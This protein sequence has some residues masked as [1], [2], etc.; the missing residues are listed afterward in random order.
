MMEASGDGVSFEDV[1]TDAFGGRASLAAFEG[2]AGVEPVT[3]CTLSLVVSGVGDPFL[4]VTEGAF[5]AAPSS[6]SLSRPGAPFSRTSAFTPVL[7]FDTDTALEAVAFS[8]RSFASE[9]VAPEAA[10]PP[11]LAASVGPVLIGLTVGAFDLDVLADFAGGTL[12][13][14]AFDFDVLA[15]FAG[16]T[17]TIGA[18]DFHV[19]ADFAAGLEPPPWAGCGVLAARSGFGA[20]T[21]FAGVFAVSLG[22]AAGF[23]VFLGDTDTAGFN[24]AR[25]GTGGAGLEPGLPFVEVF[26]GAA[27]IF[28]FVA[29]FVPFFQAESVKPF[30]N[31]TSRRFRRA[32]FRLQPE[33]PQSKD[34]G[35]YHRCDS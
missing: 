22:T 4:G 29:T 18:F 2:P 27:G 7:T 24:V 8:S 33:V 17:L 19:L 13:I 28:A 12:T 26:A 16:E 30:N 15:D 20:V 1:R 35:R 32:R 34:R 3:F 14:G 9:A 23:A 10:D 6:A 11:D 25:P 21:G 5:V 31:Q